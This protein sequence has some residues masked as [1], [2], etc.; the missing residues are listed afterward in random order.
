MYNISAL[1]IL[2]PML[3]F[4]QIPPSIEAAP[5]QIS[6]ICRYHPDKVA[7]FE[8]IISVAKASAAAGVVAGICKTSTDEVAKKQANCADAVET[9]EFIRG[10]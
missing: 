4:A 1:L 10:H 9:V 2:A 8:Y 7:C 3:S 5:A 6:E